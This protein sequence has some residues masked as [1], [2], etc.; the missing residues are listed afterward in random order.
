MLTSPITI[1]QTMHMATKITL[2]SNAG[3]EHN[4]LIIADKNTDL[5]AAGYHKTTAK[6]LRGKIDHKIQPLIYVTEQG[7]DVIVSLES[8]KTGPNL[9]EAWRKLG[10]NALTGLLQYKVEKAGV[11]NLAEHKE[12][13]A[14]ILEGLLL[15]N[16][17]FVRYKTQNNNTQLLA[18]LVVDKEALGKKEAD[19]LQTI[20]EATFY[21]RNLIN[22]P[23][24][25][26]TAEQL[27]KE[28]EKLGKEAGFK[29]EIFNKKKIESLKM[30]GLIAVNLGSPNPPTFNIMEWK[31]AKAKNKKPIV[32]VGKGVVYDTG[33]LSLKPTPNSMD[34]MKSDMGGAAAV[35]GAIYAAARAKLPLHIIALVPATE[36]RPG[37][38]AYAP[39]DV[40]KMHSGLNVEVMNTDAEGRMILADALSYA[41]KY[42]PQLVIDL[43]TL[44]G[45]AARAVGPQGIVYMGTADE[46]VKKNLLDSSYQVYERLVEFP[47]WEEYDDMIK[48]EIA[49]IKNVGGPF[50]GAT[51][52][53]MFL[54][55]FVDYPWLHLDIAGSAFLDK[56]DG[57][58]PRFGTG[59]GVRLLFDFL[60]K[61]A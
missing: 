56:P 45:A 60:K 38:N 55:H 30:G 41:K 36:N 20:T 13:V 48:S 8:D 39:G 53:G 27:S 4:R 15:T 3:K 18:Q 14:P 46:E 54:K 26:L 22:E 11:L 43:A 5:S 47:M 29:V 35:I 6:S 25:Y 58:R 31:P 7:V 23:L 32:L 49:D 57:Y 52:A 50:A 2:S 33:G 34:M 19:E 40:I 42:K 51:T 17:K 9:L 1:N 21:A 37:G 28:I 24:S 12:A 61:Q 44:T 10:S 16:Y 59:V